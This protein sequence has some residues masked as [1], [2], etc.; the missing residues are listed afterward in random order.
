M[1]R[2]LRRSRRCRGGRLGGVPLRRCLGS[3][4]TLWRR[5]QLDRPEVGV[6]IGIVGVGVVEPV[7]WE[8]LILLVLCRGR[9]WRS[10]SC[11]GSEPRRQGS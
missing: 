3:E 5:V 8:V 1:V 4:R 2:R 9:E 11:W 10:S 6:E 7:G